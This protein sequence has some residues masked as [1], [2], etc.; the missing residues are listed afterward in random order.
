M[1]AM[2]PD[3]VARLLLDEAG[4]LP[5]R[6][7]VVDDAGG[8]LTA[9]ALDAGADVRAWC[10]DLRDELDCPASTRTPPP[11]PGDGWRPDLVLWRLPKSLGQLEDTAERLAAVLTPGGR[12]LAGGRTKHM[13]RAQNDVLARSFDEVNASLGRQKSRVLR[14]TGPRRPERTWPRRR[15]LGEVGLTVVA[16]GAAFN[17]NRLDDG[18]R[19]LLGALGREAAHG[20]GRSA[21]DLGCGSGIIAT[22][23]AQRGWVVEASDVS[24]DAVASTVL[25]AG[26]NG[27]AVAVRRADGLDGAA[28]GLDLIASNPPFHRGTEKDSTPTLRMIADAGGVLA[29]GG[30]LWLVFN[31]HLPY[32]PELRRHVGPTEVVARDRHY[33]VTRTTR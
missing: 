5:D 33:V 14:A 6:V 21:L 32:L 24:T 18:T 19:L 13:T 7:L 23:L 4:S 8:S 3:A 11:S 27:V 15:H 10:D 9:A 22:W 30:R 1:G 25:T 12:V 28:S 26:A 17:T 31:S 2:T 29:P 16:H 20:A